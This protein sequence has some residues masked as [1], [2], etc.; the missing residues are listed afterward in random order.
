MV[1]PGKKEETYA[2]QGVSFLRKGRALLLV[3][4][5]AV[6]GSRGERMVGGAGSREQLAI[7][8]TKG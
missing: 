6:C 4:M 5:L 1:L 8:A 3:V 7:T 2:C